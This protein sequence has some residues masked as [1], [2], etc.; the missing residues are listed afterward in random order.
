MRYV[1]K[2][3]FALNIIANLGVALTAGSVLFPLTADS[4]S[5]GKVIL[6][7]YA[8]FAGVS[9]IAISVKFYE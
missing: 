2:R 6:A 8:I 7:L 5:L 9:F 4:V 1:R 3:R